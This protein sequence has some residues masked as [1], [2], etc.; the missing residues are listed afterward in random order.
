MRWR[1]YGL[2]ISPESSRKI[3][4]AAIAAGGGFLI[5]KVLPLWIWPFGIGLWLLWAG[6]G[7]LAVGGALIWMGWRLLR[8]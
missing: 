6:L 4:G 1:R 2:R 8:R 7:P 3:W 5:I